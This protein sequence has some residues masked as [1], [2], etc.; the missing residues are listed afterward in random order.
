MNTISFIENEINIYKEEFN[1]YTDEDSSKF[2]KGAPFVLEGN[3][4]FVFV[5][6]HGYVASPL[7]TLRL[8]K[9][10]NGYIKHFC[11]IKNRE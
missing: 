9:K 7:E 2:M 11:P 4:N 3:S 8:S 6:I 10:L 5:L 1:R